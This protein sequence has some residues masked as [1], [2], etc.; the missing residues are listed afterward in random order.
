[1]ITRLKTRMIEDAVVEIEESMST[2]V[3]EGVAFLHEKSKTLR[4]KY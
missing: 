4:D 1:M 2:A 3:G